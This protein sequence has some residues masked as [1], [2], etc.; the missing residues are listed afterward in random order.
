M[1]AV[2]NK[3]TTA[4]NLRV[5]CDNEIGALQARIA[6]HGGNM[7]LASIKKMNPRTFFVNIDAPAVTTLDPL[8]ITFDYNEDDIGSCNIVHP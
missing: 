1:I 5:I 4:L 7:F 6:G 8:V 2:T 3:Q